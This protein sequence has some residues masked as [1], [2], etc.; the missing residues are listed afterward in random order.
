MQLWQG[1]RKKKLKD[2]ARHWAARP[3]RSVE[4]D[5][6]AADPEAWQQALEEHE[7]QF[8][9]KENDGLFTV[10]PENEE[11]LQ[12]F[13]A[14]GR[15]WRFDGLSGQHLGIERP[16]IEST[17]KL[18]KIKRKKHPMIFEQIR[19]MEDAALPVLNRK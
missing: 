6:R 15:C 7:A 2:A 4:S 1:G 19:L 13:I 8:E 18:M 10:W 16:A 17:L 9:E 12:V 11:A 5:A 3:A 14:L